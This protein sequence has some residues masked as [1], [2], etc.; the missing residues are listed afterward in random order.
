M[1]QN[2]D[3]IA[4]YHLVFILLTSIL[5]EYIYIYVVKHVYLQVDTYN[6]HILSIGNL[7]VPSVKL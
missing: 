4:C 5:C 3:N 2:V 7:M 6:N 1:R